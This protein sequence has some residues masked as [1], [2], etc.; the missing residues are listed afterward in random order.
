LK[1]IKSNNSL[2]AV[3]IHDLEHMNERAYLPLMEG[4]CPDDLVSSKI[5]VDSGETLWLA[6]FA[7]SGLDWRLIKRERTTLKEVWQRNR[8]QRL[9]TAYTRL[10]VAFAGAISFIGPMI[11]MSLQRDLAT[12]LLTTCIGTLLVAMISVY[13]SATELDVLGI[14][15]T[16]AAVLTVFVGATI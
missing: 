1:Y 10:A 4:V 15:A 16:Y 8:S 7:R 2:L 6:E 9:R 12:A 11:I 3:A 14:V 5:L 13:F